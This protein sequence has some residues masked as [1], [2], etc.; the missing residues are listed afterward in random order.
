MNFSKKGSL[1]SNRK[2]YLI[3]Y[4]ILSSIILLVLSFLPERNSSSEKRETHIIP[5]KK[6]SSSPPLEVNTITVKKGMTL[7]DILSSFNFSPLQIYNLKEEV[8]P[9][10]DLSKI[11]SGQGFRVYSSPQGEVRC[12]EYDIDDE[13]YLCIHKKDGSYQAE[14]KKFPF[15]IKKRMIWGMI[16]HNLISA[17]SQQGEQ[18]YLALSL[19]EIFAWNIDF[20][21]DLRKGDS[22]K[23]I[24]EKKFLN[25]EFVGY[26][27]IQAAEFINQG[28][29]FQAFRYT[30]PDTGKSDYFDRQGNSLRKEFLKSPLKFGR[31]SSRFSYSRLH[32]ILRVYR[33]HYGV[34][35]AAP[36][37]TPVQATA[38]GTVIFA[39]WDRGSGRM[40]KIRH[41]NSYVTYYL[42]LRSFARGIKRGAKVKSGQVIGYIGSTGLSTGPH[43]DYRIKYKGKYIN[44]L[45]W[46]F[47]PAE[48]LRKEFM[49]DFQEKARN[50][51]LYLQTPTL[52]F[53]SLSSTC[54]P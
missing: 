35:Y 19:A 10:Y 53:K 32:P 1:E 12:I 46:R 8:K 18:V 7:T 28:K 24:F 52:F 17:I 31:I 44:P 20:Y 26:G 54:L 16:E 43:L 41:N 48:P 21:I 36:T 4:I 34:D 37:G 15:K 6:T 29:K 30:Y 38:E 13:N 14:I 50:Y 3:F 42:H 23:I 33:P 22:F 2:K 47:K 40:I 39:G 9:V 25:G 51:L 5:E 49:D 11:K 45:A 27:N